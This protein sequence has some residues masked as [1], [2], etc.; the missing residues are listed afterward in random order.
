[1]SEE[2]KPQ[3]INSTDG[4]QTSQSRIASYGIIVMLDALGARSESIQVAADLIDDLAALIKHAKRTLETVTAVHFAPNQRDF[5]NGK[6]I[7]PSWSVFGDSLLLVWPVGEGHEDLTLIQ[8]NL[9]VCGQYIASFLAVAF[10]MGRLLRGAIALGSYLNGEGEG[11]N[12]VTLGPAVIDAVKWHELSDWAGVIV[13]PKT[14]RHLEILELEIKST[15]APGL[16]TQQECLWW[17]YIK[18]P[19]PM[20]GFENTTNFW[21]VTW[22]A[23]FP[24]IGKLSKN[25]PDERVEKLLWIAFNRNPVPPEAFLKQHETI[26]FALRYLSRYENEITKFTDTLLSAL[27][28]PE[29]DFPEGSFP[30]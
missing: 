23:V 20:K 12:G 8:T 14:A 7:S 4:D 21:T 6:S 17:P 15:L 19:V 25:F 16:P 11:L 27:S 24:L 3:L 10:A 13:T 29:A 30:L 5:S 2:E 18:Y 26:Q 9:I 22:P 28:S 1:M